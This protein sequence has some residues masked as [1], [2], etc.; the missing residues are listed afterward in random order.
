[1][2][3]LIVSRLIQEAVSINS[4]LTWMMMK[5]KLKAREAL[6]DLSRIFFLRRNEMRVNDLK[7]ICINKLRIVIYI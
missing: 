2:K 7:L 3:E 5:K 6:K 1:M 4:P